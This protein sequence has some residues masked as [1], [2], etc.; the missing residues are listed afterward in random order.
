MNYCFSKDQILTSIE[1]LYYHHEIDDS[2]IN[3]VLKSSLEWTCKLE[4]L[5]YFLLQ[6][7]DHL[8]T[9]PI[10]E[11]KSIL[12]FVQELDNEM[13]IIF[14]GFSQN[15]IEYLIRNIRDDS[16]SLSEALITT[17]RRLAEYD[18]STALRY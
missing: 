4:I 11:R 13:F 2:I 12:N 1:I 17:Q 7:L 5:N 3:P 6:A 9:L 10:S 8:D 14:E 15:F 16:I 18:Y